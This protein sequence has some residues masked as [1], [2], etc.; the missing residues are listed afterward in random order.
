[1]KNKWIIIIG[2]LTLILPLPIILAVYLI[3]NINIF[4]NPDFWYSYMGYFGTIVLAVVALWQNENAN[5]INKRIMN[6]QLRQKIGYFNLVETIGER[7]RINKYK[8]IRIEEKTTDEQ[9]NTI[10]ENL[11]IDLKNVGEDIVLNPMVVSAKINGCTAKLTTEITAIYINETI[12]FSLENP[13]GKDEILK[14]DLSIKMQNTAGIYYTQSFNI[15]LKRLPTD[16]P[17]TFMV[18]C[19]NTAIDFK[20]DIDNGNK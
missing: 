13:K 8:D 5:I 1:M 3:G 17:V 4:N 20:E 9:N 10:E 6:Q 7:R 11:I 14:I 19:F 16:D 18:R 2:V 12:G 15:E